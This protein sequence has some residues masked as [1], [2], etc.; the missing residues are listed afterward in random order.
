MTIPRLPTL[1]VT[2][3]LLA[4]C[5][6]HVK[7]MVRPL[8]EG[9]TVIETSEGEAWHLALSGRSRQLAYLDGHLTEVWGKGSRSK[10]RVERFRI[11]RGASGLSVYVGVLD[12][13][14]GE[15]G[16][17]DPDSVG[18]LRLDDGSL[19]DLLPLRGLPVLV[20]GYVEGAQ[21][22]KVV[23]YRVLADAPSSEQQPGD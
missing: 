1:A 2:L 10:L 16:L 13:I 9:G 8:A 14:D 4:G 15:L 20:E 18:F 21:R 7:G 5:P 11:H 12:V 3:L 23:K 22:V 6:A 19:T 17:R